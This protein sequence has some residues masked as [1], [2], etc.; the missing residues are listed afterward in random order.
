MSDKSRELHDVPPLFLTGVLTNWFGVGLLAWR[1][2]WIALV[3]AL[4]TAG[5]LVMFVGAYQSR[6]KR[7]TSR[8]LRAK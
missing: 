7:N 6:S 5:T 8:E 3:A 4:L 2:Q 1:P